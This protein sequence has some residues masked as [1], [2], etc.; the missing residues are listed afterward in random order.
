MITINIKRRPQSQAN[1]VCNRHG[2]QLQE[3]VHLL[4]FWFS[5]QRPMMMILGCLRVI[6]ISDC[7][8]RIRRVKKQTP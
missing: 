1:I 8:V 2:S 7:K 4:P 5:L 3:G 6:K